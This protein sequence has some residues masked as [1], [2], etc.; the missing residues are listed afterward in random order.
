MAYLQR[1][2]DKLLA[3]ELKAS[4]TILIEGTKWCGKTTTT[5]SQIAKSTL[6]SRIPHKGASILAKENLI[7]GFFP[8]L[9]LVASTLGRLNDPFECKVDVKIDRKAYFRSMLEDPNSSIKYFHNNYDRRIK[10]K[11]DLKQFV[12]QLKKFPFRRC[13]RYIV[14]LLRIQTKRLWR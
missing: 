2:C 13:S 7:D 3:S 12:R 8:N 6:I 11:T 14:M 1:I 5:A 10:N 4:R 9:E